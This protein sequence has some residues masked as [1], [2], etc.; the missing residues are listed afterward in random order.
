MCLLTGE[1]FSHITLSA[2]YNAVSFTDI[3]DI[4]LRMLHAVP[5]RF[6]S[7]DCLH[8]IVRILLYDY[9]RSGTTARYTAKL[10][11][12]SLLSIFVNVVIPVSLKS[13]KQRHCAKLGGCSTKCT[14]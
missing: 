3:L 2:L 10:Q 7:V 5:M 6:A 9:V 13:T 12:K 14:I 4:I 1:F 8:T 11:K